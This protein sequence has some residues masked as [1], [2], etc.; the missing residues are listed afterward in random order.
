MLI[1]SIS[2]LCATARLQIDTSVPCCARVTGVLSVNQL[3]PGPHC[4][5]NAVNANGIHVNPATQL[6][7]TWMYVAT[8]DASLDG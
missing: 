3:R 7:R 2:W 5:R 8:R 1:R 6:K 4:M